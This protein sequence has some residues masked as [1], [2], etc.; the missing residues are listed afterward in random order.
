MFI[1]LF[2]KLQYSSSGQKSST[3]KQD[4][5]AATMFKHSRKTSKVFARGIT[6][7]HVQSS[8]YC[9]F[10]I[11]KTQSVTAWV[12]IQ[13]VAGWVTIQSF[14]AG[15]TIQS[16]TARATNRSVYCWN[17]SPVGYKWAT[18]QSVT[19]G[20]T[21][22]SCYCLVTIQSPFQTLKKKKKKS[23]LN[24]FFD[25]F[26]TRGGHERKRCFVFQGKKHAA[27]SN[28]VGWDQVNVGILKSENSHSKWT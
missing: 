15:V 17:S 22:Q 5:H 27:T 12:T 11:A 21:I 3:V 14:T 19:A 10:T 6:V 23:D 28:M 4:Y 2:R 20:T 16:I 26:R 1:H 25:C 24:L 13:P 8:T 18:I 9:L 7:G